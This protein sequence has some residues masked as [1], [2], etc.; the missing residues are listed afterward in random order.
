[1][2]ADRV[3]FEK[4]P[5]WRCEVKASE[6]KERMSHY[7]DI[8]GPW[9]SF[10]DSLQKDLEALESFCEGLQGVND[11]QRERIEELEKSLDLMNAKIGLEWARAERA[12]T[13]L[14]KLRDALEIIYNI[15]TRR[16]AEPE[17]ES[18]TGS[19]V[20]ACTIAEEA[21]LAPKEGI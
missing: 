12:E 16:L 4:T 10:C 11:Q 18:D 3:R 21:M 1:M 2:E 14:A 6:W 5:I 7:T 9:A 17:D 20:K 13:A 8:E 19:L 15:L